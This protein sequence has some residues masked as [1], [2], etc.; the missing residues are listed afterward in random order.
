M[1][2]AMSPAADRSLNIIPGVLD[3]RPPMPE[4]AL[5]FPIS[6]RSKYLDSRPVRNGA[7]QSLV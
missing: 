4:V 7:R 3:G 1:T 2:C 6:E 5:T